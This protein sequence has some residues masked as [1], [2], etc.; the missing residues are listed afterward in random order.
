MVIV[1]AAVSA[2]PSIG[3]R[4]AKVCFGSLADI[5]KKIIRACHLLEPL[6]RRGG[7]PKKSGLVLKEAPGY[8][9]S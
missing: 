7:V 3:G 1:A 2:T 4:S 6:D 9:L 8:P 5:C